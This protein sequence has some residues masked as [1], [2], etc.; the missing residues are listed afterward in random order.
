[1]EGEQKSGILMNKNIFQPLKVIT[2][3]LALSVGI[4]YVSAWTAPTATPPGGNTSAPINVGSTAQTKTGGLNIQGNVGIGM[5]TPTQSL[6]VA[7]NIQSTGIYA[8]DVG[9]K[10][11]Y[12][13]RGGA[14][15]GGWSGTPNAWTIT[16]DRQD[17]AI[18]GWSKTS[19]AWTGPWLYIN[20]DNGNVGIGAT[21]SNKF[22]VVGSIY[23]SGTVNAQDV[24][25]RDAG[26]WQSELVRSVGAGTNVTITG[27]V[28]N[29]VINAS[30]SASTNL[31]GGTLSN[32]YV[33]ATGCVYVG[34]IRTDGGPYDSSC[35]VG[36]YVNGMRT[37]WGGASLD[38][39][40]IRCC[41][42]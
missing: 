38:S 41:K 25:S 37:Y 17:L 31:G 23:S 6:D 10:S 36:Y 21:P 42:L 13:G 11:T 1:M 40:Y 32:G 14:I 22:D 8:Q 35:P 12:I 28:Q 4:S 18:G 5:T 9:G 16:P 7:G 20:S 33:N 19:G 2:L 26:K 30:A 27:T 39:I 24:Y 34:Q 3:A 29:P 15:T